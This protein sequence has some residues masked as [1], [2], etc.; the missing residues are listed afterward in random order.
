MKTRCRLLFLLIFLSG[1]F[2]PRAEA[3]SLALDSIATW[4]KFPH[5]CIDVY[6]WG[7]KFF[8]SYD[9]TYVVGT[10]NKFNMKFRTESWMDYYDFRFENKTKMSM[11]SDPCTSMGLYLTYLAVSVGYDVNVSKLFGGNPNA[12][13]R[14]TF[15]FSCSLLAANFYFISNDVGTH[16]SS[17]A[18]PEIDIRPDLE[19]KGINT[20][21]W[22][23]DAYYFFNR[24]HYS[25]G[26]AFSFSKLQKKSA[27]TPFA[28]FS[29]YSLNYNFDFNS[30]P[31]YMKA[32]L[33]MSWSEYF[34]H[35]KNRNYA[36]KLGYA[37]NWALPHNWLIGISEAPSVGIRTGYIN[38]P[39]K[40]STT[41]GLSNRF[42]ASAVYNH[43][44]WFVGIVGNIENNLISDKEHTLISM[45]WSVN[46][47][48][49]YRFNL[50]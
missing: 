50:W 36:V 31:V 5:F 29:Y 47:S 13:K 41:F 28:G 20:R 43:G 46:A 35:V 19:F 8:N 9:S 16:I 37:Y 33:P 18:T 2:S 26:A 24:A 42:N 1:V 22:G 6:R 45:M 14:F 7:D 12:R 44:K 39:G 11:I 23:F 30:L 48:I 15:G 32:H 10:G 49:G 38:N 3:L 34:Y 27:G 17:F 25:Q 40:S 4:G 21:Q